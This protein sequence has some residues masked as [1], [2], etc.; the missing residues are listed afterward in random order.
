MQHI[1]R[2]FRQILENRYNYQFICSSMY[3]FQNK[4]L[5]NF[6]TSL[7]KKNLHISINHFYFFLRA[8]LNT[9]QEI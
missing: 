6:Q 7:C 2:S 5:G 3:L 8:D 1:I 9:E 4:N